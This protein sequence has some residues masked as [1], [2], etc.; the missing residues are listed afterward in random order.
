[1][2]FEKLLGRNVRRKTDQLAEPSTN[3]APG[4]FFEGQL[5]GSGHFLVQGEVVGDGQVRGTV[6]LAAGAYWKGNLTADCVILSGKL[7]G[8]LVAYEKVDLTATAQITGVMTT[9]SVFI[10]EGAVVEAR[11]SRPRK[12]QVTRYNERRGQG[13]PPFTA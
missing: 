8:N 11:I 9:P 3:L 2:I 10:A 12:T 4:I 1:M 13:G 6:T 5:E 7:E